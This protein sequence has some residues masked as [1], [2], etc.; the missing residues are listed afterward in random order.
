MKPEKVVKRIE[1]PNCEDSVPDISKY[2]GRF[3]RR[4]LRDNVCGNYKTKLEE[5]AAKLRTDL[6][7]AQQLAEQLAEGVNCVEEGSRVD[8]T[9]VKELRS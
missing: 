1:C 3:L 9:G 4:H 5:T 6:L 8:M 2:R 7:A